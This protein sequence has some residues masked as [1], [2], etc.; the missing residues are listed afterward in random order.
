MATEIKFEPYND[1]GV[2]YLAAPIV[3]KPNSTVTSF[4]VSEPHMDQTYLTVEL[5]ESRKQVEF[6]TTA[7]NQCQGSAKIKNP[8]GLADQFIRIPTLATCYPAE[9][10]AIVSVKELTWGSSNVNLAWPTFPGTK[11]LKPVRAVVKG[12]QARFTPAEL[13]DKMRK[14]KVKSLDLKHSWYATCQPNAPK[15]ITIGHRFELLQV[16]FE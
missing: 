15:F 8:Q 2:S 7:Y 5:D 14:G 9:G 16:T 3:F 6:K 11:D 4:K 10:E 12:K 1:N 13:Q